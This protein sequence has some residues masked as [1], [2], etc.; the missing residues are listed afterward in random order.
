M[1]QKHLITTTSKAT[2]STTLYKKGELNML[3]INKIYCINSEEQG[4]STQIRIYKEN[5]FYNFALTNSY[6]DKFDFQLNDPVA[7]EIFDVLKVLGNF[8]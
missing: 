6:G 4:S 5:G 1:Q 7:S 8:V 3:T 2:P